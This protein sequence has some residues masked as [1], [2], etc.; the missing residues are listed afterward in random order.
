MN[1]MSSLAQLIDFCTDIFNENS[2]CPKSLN[3][4]Q[5]Y[6]SYWKKHNDLS[7]QDPELV[8]L[9][10]K[11]EENLALA[12]EQALI[13]SANELNTSFMEQITVIAK[14]SDTKSVTIL[15]QSLRLRYQQER[16]LWCENFD[17]DHS[18]F[19]SFVQIGDLFA[20]LGVKLEY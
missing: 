16:K 17:T 15:L 7:T 8:K 9:L 2:S 18:K 4:A 13:I 3:V 1:K 19:K 12:N 5:K 10:Q 6:V 20:Q 14:L 11:L